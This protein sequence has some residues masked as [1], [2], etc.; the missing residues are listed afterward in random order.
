MGG[1]SSWVIL[2][3]AISQLD[4]FFFSF[5]T[6]FFIKRVTSKDAP[7]SQRT[8]FTQFMRDLRCVRPVV[9][10]DAAEK[11]PR[12]WLR[13]HAGRKG[14]GQGDGYSHDH[15]LATQQR[16]A[17]ELASSQGN[18]SLVV[19]HGCGCAVVEVSGWVIDEGGRQDGGA[20]WGVEVVVE[21]SC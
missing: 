10:R 16:V 13:E 11:I 15:L 4:I 9:D 1:N 17:D 12:C 14:Q 6:F 5:D 19:R 8:R 2:C 20:F 7:P 3:G 21:L 18:G